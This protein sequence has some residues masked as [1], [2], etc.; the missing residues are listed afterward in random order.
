M[1]PH[2]A[3]LDRAI[4]VEYWGLSTLAG[5]ATDGIGNQ[6]HSAIAEAASRKA[7]LDAVADALG[8]DVEKFHNWSVTP[9]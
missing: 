2:L 6:R 8:A 7:A 1:D 3:K 4:G 5:A 9:A